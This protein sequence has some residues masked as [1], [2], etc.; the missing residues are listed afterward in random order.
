MSHTTMIRRNVSCRS[1]NM[2]LCGGT[3]SGVKWQSLKARQDRECFAHRREVKAF[4]M[5]YH[6]NL[7]GYLQQYCK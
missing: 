4:V 7:R 6:N 2:K 3:A 5:L 1:L